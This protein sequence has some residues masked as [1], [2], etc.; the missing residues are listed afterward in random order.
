MIENLCL[1]IR[2]NRHQVSRIAKRLG[3]T[4]PSRSCSESVRDQQSR[5]R[6]KMWDIYPH[7]RGMLGKKHSLE[8]LKIVAECSRRSFARM[9]NEQKINRTRKLL[10]TRLQKY[11]TLAK[12]R[13]NTSWK[14]GW[15]EIGG[16]KKY[17]RSKWEA[18][19]ARYLEFLRLKGRVASW[20]H[21]PEVFWFDGIKKGVTNYT[22]DF[23]V[24]NINGSIEYHE[25]K[26]WMDPKS[27]TKIK[28]MKKYHPSVNLLVID[29]SIYKSIA[30]WSRLIPGWEE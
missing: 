28:R 22:P 9:T 29:A 14:S 6:K 26:G 25:V 1:K 23:R 18:N 13:K 8:T 10:M 27:V 7:P 30:Q 17:Y 5:S 15:R 3:L 11:G 2:R 16:L 24:T 20:E 12:P 21:E 4:N 19:Y